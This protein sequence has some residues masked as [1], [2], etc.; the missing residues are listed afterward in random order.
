[1]ILTNYRINVSLKIS[2]SFKIAKRLVNQL[3]KV[4]AK[5]WIIYILFHGCKILDESPKNMIHLAKL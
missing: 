4:T 2:V 3:L 1:M 5:C